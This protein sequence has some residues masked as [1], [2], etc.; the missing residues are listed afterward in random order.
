MNNRLLAQR[1]EY[2][3]KQAFEALSESDVLFQASLYRGAVNRAYYAMF[4]AVLALSVVKGQV[5]SKHSGLIAFFDLEYIK[6]GILPKD[7]SKALHLAFDQRQS[8]DY[9]EVWSVDQTETAEAIASAKEFVNKVSEYL[10]ANI[11][12][13]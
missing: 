4:Y 8:F 1:A 6:K 11:H 12:T 13:N 2:R 10:A 3:L 9:G 7:L 5:I